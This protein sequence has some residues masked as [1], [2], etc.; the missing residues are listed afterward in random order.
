MSFLTPEAINRAVTHMN[1]DH[2]DGNLY[3]VQAFHD[4]TATGADMLTLDA[5]SGTWEYILK[6]GTTKTAVIP[7][8]NALQKREDIRHAVVALYK[9]AC[10][11]LGVTEAGNGHTEENNLH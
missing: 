11:D 1:K 10:T 8:P 5:T 6:D 7:F 3:I 4:R 9:Q 2:A